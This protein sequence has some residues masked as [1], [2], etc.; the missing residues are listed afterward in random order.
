VSDPGLS[1]VGDTTPGFPKPQ[2]YGARAYGNT[3]P[4]PGM[5]R[6]LLVRPDGRVTVF[7]GKVEYG[8]NIR[9]GLAVE[10]ADELR[11]PLASVDV[12]LGD[13]DR[14]PWDMGTFGSQSTAKVGLH[15]RMAA[16][17]AREALLELASRR[18]DLPREDLVV[19]EG[20]IASNADP[21]RAFSYGELLAD[22]AFEREID[23]EAPL[24]E[25]RDFTVM[26]SDV[27][28]IDAEARVTGAAVYSQDVLRPG[29]LF[30][31]ILRA[32]SFGATLVEADTTAA[33]QMPGVVQVVRDGDLIA[34]LAEDDESADRALHIVQ[35]TWDGGAKGSTID[36][37]QMMAD[38]KRDPV[39][40][41]Q[42]GD[43]EEAFRHADHV[44]EAT[45]YGPHIATLPME[46]RAAVAE[47]DGDKLTVWAGTQRP[48]GIRT[49][50]AGMFRIPEADVRV[51]ATEIGGGFGTK[52]WFP[53]SNEAA[54]LAR[55]AGRPVRVA[56]NRQEDAT[57]GNFRPA[58]LIDIK[59]A[60]RSDGTITAWQFEGIHAG[61]T[62]YIAQREAG[63][64]YAVENVSATVYCSATLV[65]VGSYRSLGAA[66]NNFARESHIDEIAA[67]LGIDPFEMRMRN[68]KEP[69]YRH[70]LEEAA[71]AFGYEPGASPT[72]RGVGIAIGE[73]VGS[74]VATCVELAVEGRE[75]RVRRVVTAIDCGL[76]VNPEGVRNQVEGSTVMG[77]GGALYE[78]IEIGDG[79]ILNTSLSRYQVPRITD[80]PEIEVVLAGDPSQPSTGAGEP[81]IVT[82][83]PAV[84]NAVFDATGQRIRELPLKR[85]LR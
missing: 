17:T 28:R 6:W 64:P 69:R 57:E 23:E 19:R 77:L 65:R 68:M 30:A 41:Q 36:I 39:P 59:S 2:G 76:V 62:G 51:I 40:V 46:P 22:E 84:A 44:L 73:D 29:M 33:E 35:A 49:E 82:I 74:Y 20:K 9:T 13:T 81:G 26:G 31:R 15:L 34:V 18:L 3:A 43:V 21:G 38:T 5:P 80:T 45:Y 12:V 42:T 83:A 10:V 55:I 70:V 8:Q 37:P 78:A 52:S 32:P 14:V 50:L 71:K 25:A 24:T 58:A 27:R 66:L 16:A 79:V 60:F 4:K 48:F 7:A 47:W 54:K 11:V 1:I 72:K 63:M 75:I 53:T 67:Q 85:Q 56:Y 61:P